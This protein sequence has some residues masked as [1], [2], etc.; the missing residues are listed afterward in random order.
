MLC[1]LSL[2]T[3]KRNVWRKLPSLGV[4][5]CVHCFGGMAFMILAAT[6]T[7]GQA[8]VNRGERPRLWELGATCPG[9]LDSH[10][11]CL[12]TRVVRLMNQGSSQLAAL[13]GWHCGFSA[14]QFPLRGALWC[15][16]IQHE[17]GT[18]ILAQGEPKRRARAH[19]PKKHDKTI[20]GMAM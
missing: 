11:Q 19:T 3:A 12:D 4:P 10:P 1:V 13:P 18:L 2:A 16:L 5:S 7:A 6:T 20:G 14:D 9:R 15:V 17:W 8:L